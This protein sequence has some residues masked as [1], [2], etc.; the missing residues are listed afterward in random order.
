M[1][2]RIVES[3]I[4]GLLTIGARFTEET[5]YG[6]V[7]DPVSAEHMVRQYLMLPGSAIFTD[8]EYRCISICDTE[9]YFTV[10]KIGYISKFW[11]APEHRNGRL[12]LELLKVSMDYLK[13]CSDVFAAATA[14]IKGSSYG[15]FLTKRGFRDCGMM[16]RW[17]NLQQ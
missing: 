11:V 16:M 13:D 6:W 15:A 9:S 4:P 7:F 3:D 12:S 5:D 14:N 2:R 8:D 10:Q 1:I 17:E